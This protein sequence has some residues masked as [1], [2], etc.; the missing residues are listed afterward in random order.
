MQGLN[1]DPETRAL[2]EAVSQRQ[3]ETNAV[4]RPTAA[5][6]VDYVP[7]R[8]F[9]AYYDLAYGLQ[10][11]VLRAPDDNER[12][13]WLGFESSTKVCDR[14]AA[15]RE[16]MLTFQQLQQT[17]WEQYA[18]R[19]G[20]GA[21][22][23]GSSCDPPLGVVPSAGSCLREDGRGSGCDDDPDRLELPYFKREYRAVKLQAS[24]RPGTAMQT[25]ALRDKVE[26][27]EATLSGM[28]AEGLRMTQTAVA[29]ISAIEAV[30]T[31]WLA[32]EAT[33]L[34]QAYIPLRR[35]IAAIK[36]LDTRLA[37]LRVE[38]D[39][40]KGLA[41]A[42][43]RSVAAQ[44][45]KAKQQRSDLDNTSAALRHDALEADA[46][47]AATRRSAAADRNG[48]DAM[49]LSED[50]LATFTVNMARMRPTADVLFTTLQ[51]LTDA[52]ALL[53][54]ASSRK[55]TQAFEIEAVAEESRLRHAA[56][57]AEQ[58]RLNALAFARNQDDRLATQRAGRLN[59]SLALQASACSRTLR[60]A[61]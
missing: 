12:L 25:R 31:N 38:Y 2:L 49:A 24:D 46:A 8:W 22:A 5:D 43:A 51:N 21:R 3:R 57:D 48:Y 11:N 39:R 7:W 29:A 19:V 27:L 44:T 15:Q 54:Q 52:K 60:P 1:R 37:G 14:S 53:L 61:L 56:A 20:Q 28:E 16:L 35:E 33:R 9:A 30:H 13:L 26:A 18:S 32:L 41:D 34:E 42:A 45:Q 58:A 17:C 55:A 6:E 23:V 10:L 50:L 59:V 4:G 47:L 40:I 36:V